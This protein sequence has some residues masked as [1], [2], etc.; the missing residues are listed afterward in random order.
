MHVAS[1][2]GLRSRARNEKLLSKHNQ[3]NSAV[4]N[5]PFDSNRYTNGYTNAVIESGGNMTPTTSVGDS[6]RD[7]TGE[8]RAAV[9]RLSKSKSGSMMT[10]LAQPSS[11]SSSGSE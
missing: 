7:R 2:S 8:F 10:A 6:L 4:N 5:T 11:S 1:H 3:N 9:D